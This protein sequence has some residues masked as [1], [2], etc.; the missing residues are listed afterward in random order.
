MK[1]LNNRAGVG[2]IRER[3]LFLLVPATCVLYVEIYARVRILHV[4]EERLDL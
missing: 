3:S 4:H 1:D 2:R